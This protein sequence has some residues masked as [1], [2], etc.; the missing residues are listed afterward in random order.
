MAEQDAPG[1]SLT[2]HKSTITVTNRRTGRHYIFQITTALGGS[3][4]GER[5]VK[6]LIGPDP[7][8]SESWATFVLVKAGQVQ[9]LV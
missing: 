1:F 7:Q 5:L 6:E 3:M 2:L 9:A 4:S 8:A